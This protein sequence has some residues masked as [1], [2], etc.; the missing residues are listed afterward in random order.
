MK[1]TALSTFIVIAIIALNILIYGY[2]I[3]QN[4]L[5]DEIKKV[6]NFTLKDYNGKSHSLKDYKK[7][8]AIVL[9]FIS[10]Q[11]PVSNSYNEKMNKIY[12]DYH[13]K[14]IAFIGINANRTEDISTIK[15]HAENHDFIFTIL[16]DWNNVI[17]DRLN[18]QVTPEIFV[19]NHNF[20]VLYHGRIDNAR[21]SGP[22]KNN[23][24]RNA[25]DEILDSKEV[26]VKQTRALG[27]TIKRVK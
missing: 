20:E 25:L 6:E 10:T 19:L 9:M 16:K 12:D 17:A 18:A 22:A 24:L 1:K 4:Q 15:K 27:C 21:G 5:P 11:C 14:N 3:N 13:S 23:D 7:A 2:S 8:K 26:A